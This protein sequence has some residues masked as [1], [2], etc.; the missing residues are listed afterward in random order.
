MRT[1]LVIEGAH[2][3]A[4]A[5]DISQITLPFAAITARVLSTVLPELVIM[6]LFGPGF[7]AIEALAQLERLGY[8]GEVLVRTPALP[9]A[10]IV[11]RELASAVPSL[12][13]RLTGPMS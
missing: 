3:A 7:D 11:Q 9:N 1:I 4:M 10:R 6:P 12:N 5:S 13:V 2:P 8:R